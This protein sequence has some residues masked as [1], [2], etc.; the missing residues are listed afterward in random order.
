MNLAAAVGLLACTLVVAASAGTLPLVPT[1]TCDPAACKPSENCQCATYVSPL[2]QEEM[3]QFVLYTHDD[4]IMPEITDAIKETVGDRT[5]PNGCTIP[6]TW[7]TIKYGTEPNCNLVK[8]L[9]REGHEIALHTR[10]HVRLDAPLTNEQK[11]QMKSVKSWLNETCGIPLEHM[12]GMRDPFLVNNPDTR[13]VQHEMGLL[14]DSTINE[15]WTNDGLWPTSA[16]GSARLLP[17]TMD[18]GIP[19]ICNAVM[20]GVCEQSER[21]PGLWEVPVWVLQTSKYPMDAYAMDPGGDVYALLKVNFDAEKMYEGQPRGFPFGDFDLADVMLPEDDD[22]DIP[23]GSDEEQEEDL[24]TES[25]F[26][27]VLVVDNL[28]AVPAEKY[29]KLTAILTKIFGGSGR[30]REGGLFHPQDEATKRS[31]GYAFVEYEN[32]EQARAAQFVAHIWEVRTGRRLRTFDGPQEE[33]AVGALARPDGGMKWPAFRWGG[34]GGGAPTY[35]AHMKRNAISVYEAPEMGM[36]DK[37]SVKME[38]VQDWEWSPSTSEA[39][40]CAYQAEQGNLPARVVIM[41][42]PEREEL[43]QKNLFSVAGIKLTWHPQ[44]DYLAVQVD[45]WTKTKKSTNTN[46]ELFSMREKDIP[47]DML[48]LPNKGEKILQFA[49]EPRGSR[50]ALLHGDGGRPSAPLP[51]RQQSLLILAACPP[52]FKT[53][54]DRFFQLI[55]RPRPPSQL[56][57]ERQREIVKNLR[58][59][60]KRYEEED[61]ALLAQADTEFVGE[62]ERQLTEWRSWLASKQAYAQEREQF[63]RAQLG[64]RAAAHDRFT[65]K[66]VEVSVVLDVKEEKMAA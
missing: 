65:V 58:K 60:S 41:R 5:N 34:G 49:W 26:S 52:P 46:F 33:Y 8:Q 56:P 59:Y 64:E 63:A 37:R 15:H 27:N 23:S 1:Y 39:A 4:A 36:L 10:D 9:W 57:E 31:K 47:I 54:H 42:L 44:G 50:F 7:F 38:D 53:P 17:Y 32:A 55:W 48:E 3:P 62:R 24:Q 45:K 29:D 22:M 30:I 20:D 11:D 61:E 25:G 12:V 66:A 13:E 40:L 28:P 18:S 14:Y 16:N 21:Y 6:L 2:P 51:L 19:Q 43:R 35:L